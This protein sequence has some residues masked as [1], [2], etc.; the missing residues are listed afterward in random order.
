MDYQKIKKVHMVYKTHLD[1]GFTDLGQRVLDR[2]VNEYIPHSVRL[3][4]ELNTRE[5]RKFI[6]T[7]GSYL[8]DYYLKHASA[9]ACRELEQAIEDGHICWH[10]LACTTHTELLD[11]DLFEYS[12]NIGEKLDQRFHKR[13]IAAKMTD[14]PGHTIAIVDVMATRGIQFLHIG[15]NA[16]SMVPKVPQTFVWKHGEND[17]IVQYSTQYGSP[18]YVEGMNEVLE[19]AHTGDNM[20]PQSAED[21]ECEF[22]RIQELYPNAVVE[23]STLDEYAKAL[24]RAKQCLPVVEEEI[25]DTWIHGIASDPWKISRYEALIQLKDKWQSE[26]QFD[27]NCSYY[28][29]YM[30]G[31]MLI[32]EHTWGLDYKKYLADFKNWT[33][34]DFKKARK[35]DITTL[36]FLTNRNAQMLEVLNL[37][38]KRYRNGHFTGSYAQYESSHEEQRMYLDKAIVSLPQDKKLEAISA[39]DNC[40]PIQEDL[41]GDIIAINQRVYISGWSIQID[42]TGALTRLERDGKNWSKNGSIGQLC[43]ENFNALNCVQN[44]YSYNRAF[45]E[46]GCWSEGDFS[47]PGLECVE[48]LEHGIY[49]FGVQKI[50][51]KGKELLICLIGDEDAVTNYG[52]P[53]IAQIKYRFDADTVKCDLSWFEKD[54]NRMPEALWFDF[55]LDVE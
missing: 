34:A 30:M 43:Y 28:D 29:D 50:V 6:W 39:M 23:A 37:D 46:N 35:D 16:S 38:F 49:N 26:G 25:G 7:V 51:R 55:S 17:I 31:L 44:Y 52:S 11:M 40:S 20:G 10:A 27:S 5:Q 13:T 54:A 14:V 48:N 1:I 4:L 33:K 19:F 53:K 45:Y 8:I 36:E 15:V 18:G 21:I 12:M 32:A 22:A 2:Y 41:Q 9:T 3:A 24:V 42:G 47:K